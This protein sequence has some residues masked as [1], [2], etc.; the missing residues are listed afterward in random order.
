MAELV[1]D[2]KLSRDTLNG[3]EAFCFPF[4]EYYNH[5]IEALKQAGFKM[6][7]IGGY[8]KAKRGDDLYKI[9]RIPLTR[10]TTISQY[11]NYIN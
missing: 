3:T 4:Y 2:L 5:G 6:A 11:A 1:A 9:P 10:N 8:R 7:F